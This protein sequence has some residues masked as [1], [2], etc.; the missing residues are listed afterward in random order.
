[1]EADDE[2]NNTIFYSIFRKSPVEKSSNRNRRK[3]KYKNWA[4]GTNVEQISSCN[5]RIDITANASKFAVFSAIRSTIVDFESK[6]NLFQN[7]QDK[8]RRNGH[9]LIKSQENDTDGDSL[10]GDVTEKAAVIQIPQ[11]N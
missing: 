9:N 10:L 1:M 11:V 7:I 4:I 8:V 6:L 2:V 3:R 5:N